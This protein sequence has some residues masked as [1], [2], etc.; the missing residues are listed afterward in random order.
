MAD[1]LAGRLAVVTGASRGI[2]RAVAEA[3]HAAGA[4]VVRIAR[5]LEPAR[6][7]RRIDLPTDLTDDEVRTRTM[8]AVL[9]I[10]T[11]DLVVNNAGAF[12]MAHFEDQTLEGLDRLY[13]A[14]LRA[15]FAVAK[16]LLPSMRRAG[17]GRHVLIGSIADY[18]AFP[19]NAAYAATK[20]GARGLHQVLRAELRGTGVLCTLISPGP[21]DTPLWD[22]FDPDRRDDLMS[23]HQ[24]L[25][26]EHV[27]GAVLWV[28]TQSPKVEVDLIRL[29]PA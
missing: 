1:R 9:R 26:P 27:A 5:S 21:T 7:D 3:L 17:A 29:G 16:A 12:E 18:Q 25:R 13:Q 15:P 22:P 28:A 4:T 11:P 14:N 8:D 10:G 2:G 24:M 23:R 19:G 6:V 20:F